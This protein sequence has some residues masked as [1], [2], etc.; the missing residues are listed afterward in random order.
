M[1]EMTLTEG[2]SHDAVM[3]RHG[4]ITNICSELAGE[5]QQ[6]ALTHTED[7]FFTSHGEQLQQSIEDSFLCSLQPQYE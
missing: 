4:I 7:W 2:F 5:L 6:Q 3:K 1:Y